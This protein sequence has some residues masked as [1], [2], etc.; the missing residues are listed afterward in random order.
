MRRSDKNLKILK[1][2]CVLMVDLDR[3]QKLNSIR[4]LS[5]AALMRTNDLV[6]HTKAVH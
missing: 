3:I 2:Y 5:V 4:R 6:L 1:R